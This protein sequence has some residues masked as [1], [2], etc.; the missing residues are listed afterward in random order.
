[1]C[2]WI[3]LDQG[4]RMIGKMLSDRQ[5][6]KYYR[7]NNKV[8]NSLLENKVWFSH[9]D[10][11]NDP[12]DARFSISSAVDE[13]ILKS[14]SRY[15]IDENKD[16]EF[17]YSV[18]S[19]KAQ[20]GERE[21]PEDLNSA[22]VP[23]FSY[24]FYFTIE[25]SRR[26]SWSL[27]KFLKNEHPNES[28]LNTFLASYVGLGICSFAATPH[29]PKMWA[30]YA[31]NHSGICVMYD[32][33][34]DDFNTCDFVHMMSV[35]YRNGQIPVYGA[36]NAFSIGTILKQLSTKSDDWVSEKE[37]RI[38]GL[39]SANKLLKV[40]GLRIKGLCFGLTTPVEDKKIIQATIGKKDP[41]INFYQAVKNN[42]NLKI[43]WNN[44][45]DPFEGVY[46]EPL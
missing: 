26:D 9:P 3:R 15:L 22:K 44:L 16:F 37:I 21:D 32:L 10:K 18:D 30:H 20:I 25:N 17:E 6:Y 1:M 23:P 5:I 13:K 19:I 4:D 31:D 14:V 39:S 33:I 40:K 24:S 2:Q 36:S 34:S 11:F 41:S 38:I 27:I 12:F 7:I 45:S 28:E 46:Y 29:D 42:L 8:I 43:N 35:E